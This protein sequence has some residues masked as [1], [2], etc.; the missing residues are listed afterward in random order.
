MTGSSYFEEGSSHGTAGDQSRVG[1]GTRIRE[2]ENMKNLVIAILAVV[3]LLL[4]GW[5]T[6]DYSSN[7]TTF[8]IETQKIKRDADRVVDDASRAFDIKIEK[9]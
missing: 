2:A 1:R 5:I 8:S 9:K 6:Y 7:R 3:V 4:A